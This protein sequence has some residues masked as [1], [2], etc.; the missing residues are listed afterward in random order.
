MDCVIGICRSITLGVFGNHLLARRK[1]GRTWMFSL[2]IREAW[3]ELQKKTDEGKQRVYE[4]RN[5]S[6]R[7]GLSGNHPCSP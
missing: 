4:A 7:G 3:E 2:V 6:V 5:N 1:G